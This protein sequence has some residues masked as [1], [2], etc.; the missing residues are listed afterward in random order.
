MEWKDRMNIIYIYIYI[1]LIKKSETRMTASILKQDSNIKGSV[2]CYLLGQ[3]QKC[4][5]WGNPLYQ[6]TK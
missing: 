6:A 5:F 1:T 3:E 4:T 2:E